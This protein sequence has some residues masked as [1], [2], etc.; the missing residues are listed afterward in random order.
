MNRKQWRAQKHVRRIIV[1]S[2]DTKR[3]LT[4][5]E[6]AAYF[7]KSTNSGWINGKMQKGV[8]MEEIHYCKIGGSPMFYRE[9]IEDL[10]ISGNLRF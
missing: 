7:G 9:I 6:L 4:K 10:I 3:L 8:L 1:A 2:L 5:E